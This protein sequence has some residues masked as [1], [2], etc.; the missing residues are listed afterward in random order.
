MIISFT[1]TP[2]FYWSRLLRSI[3]LCQRQI[4]ADGQWKEKER[5]KS[6]F[7]TGAICS[8]LAHAAWF[9]SSRTIISSSDLSQ[10]I[11]VL[12]E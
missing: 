8:P 7:Y 10:E 9:L 4:I 3:L 5:E 11:G 6:C 12:T 2:R 1:L